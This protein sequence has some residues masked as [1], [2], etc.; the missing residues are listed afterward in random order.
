V[1]FLHRLRREI[2]PPMS[3][4]YAALVEDI[5]EN[6]LRD[7]IVL[8]DRQVLDGRNRHRAC[9]EIGIEAIA[10]PWDGR[11]DPLSYVISKN[12][13]RRHLN[14]SQRAMVADKI[15]NLKE[16]RPSSTAPIGAVSQSQAA[17]TM[18]VG[19]SSV[20]NAHVVFPAIR[21]RLAISVAEKAWLSR[22]MVIE[23]KRVFPRNTR[24]RGLPGP[25]LRNRHL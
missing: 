8:L 25:P 5:R 21:A 18:N 23:N 11:G 3:D 1:R 4:E 15:A 24:A 6:G 7:P 17:K 20:Q 9:E 22:A 14:E 12:L 13:R 16:G 10:R 19:R 2:F